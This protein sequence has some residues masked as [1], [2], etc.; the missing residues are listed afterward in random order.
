MGHHAHDIGAGRI[1]LRKPELAGRV[2]RHENAGAVQPDLKGRDIQGVPM[3]KRSRAFLSDVVIG[4]EIA[5]HRHERR[6]VTL[7]QSRVKAAGDH[8]LVVITDG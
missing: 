2:L 5:D 8:F 6:F 7:E 3:D 1:Q 4:I